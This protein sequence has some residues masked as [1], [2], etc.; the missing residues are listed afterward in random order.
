VVDVPAG[1]V[2]ERAV[3]FVLELARQAWPGA[4]RQR[5]DVG[6]R[7]PAKRVNHSLMTTVRSS[8]VSKDAVRGTRNVNTS[9]CVRDEAIT[10]EHGLRSRGL[11]RLLWRLQWI[12]IAAARGG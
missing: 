1:E 5:R 12:R 10:A 3:S 9:Y 11:V 4:R 2:G 6:G 7:A 8:R